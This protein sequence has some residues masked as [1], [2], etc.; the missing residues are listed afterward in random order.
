MLHFLYF[1]QGLKGAIQMGD[2]DYYA[3]F[4]PSALPSR[5]YLRLALHIAEI[6]WG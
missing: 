5:L 2:L 1:I 6:L 4:H 3:I